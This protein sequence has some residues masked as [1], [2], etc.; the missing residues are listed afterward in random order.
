MRCAGA[1][2]PGSGWNSYNICEPGQRSVAGAHAAFA[3][4]IR[5]DAGGWLRACGLHPGLDRTV[6]KATLQNLSAAAG[7]STEW[8]DYLGKPHTVAEDSQ[9]AILEAMTIP[10]RS[11]G[12][13]SAST[14]RLHAEQLR[15]PP[16]LTATRGQPVRFHGKAGLARLILEDGESR[17]IEL[18]EAQPGFATMR[19]PPRIGYHC[20]E[21]GDSAITLAVSPSRALRAS[22]LVAHRRPW[23]VAAQLYSLNYEH[24]FG[25]FADL[26][27][28]CKELATYGA[29]AVA[30]SPLTALF[31]ARPE[32]AAPYAPSSRLYLNALYA[33][34]PSR[35][36][37]P[38]QP[39]ID[40][41]TAGARKLQE[42][43]HSHM[44][45]QRSG[46][47]RR[48]FDT[49]VRAGGEALLNHAR[50]EALD[51]RFRPRGLAHWRDWPAD[52]ANATSPAVLA[53]TANDPEVELHL[54]LQWC[55]ERG[56]AAAGNAARQAGMG[57][58]LITDL[59]VGMDGAG[60]HAWSQP[61]DIL[62]GLEIGAPPDLL[63]P[64]GQTWGLTGFSPTSLRSRGMQP[65]LATLRAALRHAG[66]VRL[67]HV[68]GLQR[69]WVVPE[70][71][72]ASA[73][74]YL[75]YPFEDFVR[76]IALESHRH[77]AIVIGEDLGTV[78]VDFRARCR[79]AGLAGMRV[80]W[81]ERT[82]TGTFRPPAQ[83]DRAAV[84]MT[85]THDLATVAGWWHGRD[86]AWRSG[87][88]QASEEAAQQ[89]ARCHDKKRLWQAMVSSRAAKG[90]CPSTEQADKVVDDAIAHVAGGACE[91]ALIA[92][93]DILAH[94]EQPNLP[95]TID[96]HPNWRR[97]L[98]VGNGLNDK[99]VQ[100]RLRRLHLVRNKV[101]P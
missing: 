8:R 88:G 12:D 80:L 54:Y 61:L 18:T 31:S 10:C 72:P 84:A 53:L 11:A 79:K 20:L 78:P 63:A 42:L 86:I 22:D 34:L 28:L 65:F 55:A 52:Y 33:P 83:W 39:L 26:A 9:R 23:G 70:G 59:A 74:A 96:Q 44:Q 92:M 97:R 16:L 21:Y 2:A 95:G 7:L 48:T 99:R 76:L 101:K 66:G 35:T 77:R 32:H 68:M 64:Q 73:G 49:F 6:T 38:Q 90:P 17:D 50:F 51:A 47:G 4:S 89:L 5:Y 81:F 36:A 56:L 19:V 45:F 93:E 15:P 43:R 46:K 3:A 40:W 57:I 13:L 29:D 82:A 62:T 67:D 30:V 94:E 27:K 37:D 100:A 58:G 87:I 85:S 60:S 1:M 91:L 14:D 71:K 41:A 24:E 69:L 25:D 98:P 75:R